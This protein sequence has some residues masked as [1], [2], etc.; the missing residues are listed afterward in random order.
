MI[1]SADREEI[2]RGAPRPDDAMSVA[3][4]RHLNL[5][6]VSTV[7]ARETR[8]VDRPPLRSLRYSKA[9]LETPIS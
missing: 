9:Q 2:G 3:T 4:D 5:G 8:A 7:T 1:N 6:G